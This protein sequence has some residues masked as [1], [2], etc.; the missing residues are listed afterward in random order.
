M[1]RCPHPCVF[2]TGEGPLCNHRTPAEPEKQPWPPLELCRVSPRMLRLSAWALSLALIFPT[3]HLRVPGPFSGRA[4][5]PVGSSAV[6]WAW[7]QGWPSGAQGS[8]CRLLLASRPA[9]AV[10]FP[11]APWRGQ[12]LPGIFRRRRSEATAAWPSPP[13]FFPPSL[14]LS[15]S[16]ALHGG[17]SL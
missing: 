10:W 14:L 15:L 7:V 12:G 16:G 13:S 1:A 4:S 17:F 9:G 5:L 3:G 11:S 2:S 6:S 8:W